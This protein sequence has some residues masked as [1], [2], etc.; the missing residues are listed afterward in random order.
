[1]KEA[2][3]QGAGK[4]SVSVRIGL[5]FLHRLVYARLDVG[6]QSRCTRGSNPNPLKELNYGG[7]HKMLYASQPYS[8]RTESKS[9]TFLLVAG[10]PTPVGP[11][12][13][14]EAIG[15]FLVSDRVV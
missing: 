5:S 7:N 8:L 10:R 9:G 4:Y 2:R 13:R 3:A 15:R 11:R 14:Q 12:K 1:M 6:C